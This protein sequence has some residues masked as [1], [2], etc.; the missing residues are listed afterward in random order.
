V[1]ASTLVACR[2]LDARVGRLIGAAPEIIPII[3]GDGGKSAVAWVNRVDG[4][5]YDER[6]LREY[7]AEK[8][9]AGLLTGYVI[10]RWEQWPRYSEDVAA[11]WLVVS[12]LQAIGCVVRIEVWC[13]GVLVE[14]ST[15]S[16]CVSIRQSGTIFPLVVSQLA[17][18][19]LGSGDAEYLISNPTPEAV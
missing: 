9:A 1:T 12:H 15:L 17:V 5:W 7:L 8:Q 4:P 10:G 11:A 14:A 16:S 6:S 13:D 3:T 18:V 19:A 2:E